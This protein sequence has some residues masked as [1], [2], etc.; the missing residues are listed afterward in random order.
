MR[1]LWRNKWFI[2]VCLWS[3]FLATFATTLVAIPADSQLT[4]ILA[5]GLEAFGQFLD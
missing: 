1:R 5:K 3:V 4:I 2:L